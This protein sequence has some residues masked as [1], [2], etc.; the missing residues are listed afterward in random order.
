MSGQAVA[1]GEVAN[2]RQAG[3]R[4]TR[5]YV[6]TFGVAVVLLVMTLAGAFLLDRRFRPPVGVRLPDVAGVTARGGAGASTA[7]N[8]TVSS[9]EAHVIV[10]PRQ[11]AMTPLEGE[12]EDAYWHFLDVYSDAVLK[13]DSRRLSDVL[14]GDALRWTSNEIDAVRQGGYPAKVIEDDR[15]LRFIQVTTASA[16]VEDTYINRSVFLNAQTGQPYPRQGADLR[17]RQVYEFRRFGTS[18]KIVT[19]SRDII[20]EAGT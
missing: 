9:T 7:A 4:S 8:A 15:I 6:F 16:T 19:G 14:D 12:V 20:G 18:W 5:F 13:M 3:A 10:H 2:T 1:G 17:V 11:F